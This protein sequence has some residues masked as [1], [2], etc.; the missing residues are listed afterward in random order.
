MTAA[1]QFDALIE[2]RRQRRRP[3][4]DVLGIALDCHWPGA[5]ITIAADEPLTKLDTRGLA[6]LVVVARAVWLRRDRERDALAMLSRGQP[7]RL[8]VIDI[9]PREPR[10]VYSH[11]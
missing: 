8:L 3:A 4:S 11:G 1:Q 7:K 5:D 9:G 6:G 2:Q 10:W